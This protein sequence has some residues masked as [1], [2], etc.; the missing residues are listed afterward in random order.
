MNCADIELLIC[1]YVDGALGADDKAA[2]EAHLAQCPECAELAEESAAAVKF[3]GRA[4]AVE[5]PPQL[6]TRILFD[7]PWRQ[8][9]STSGARRWLDRFLGPVL[10]PRIVMGMAMTVLSFS[11]LFTSMKPFKPTDFEP[12]KVW[13]QFE[14]R[15]SRAWAR[16]VKYYDNLK[17]VYQIQTMLHEWQQ[18][19]EE[20]QRQK[21]APAALP[22]EHR[23]PAS[24]DTEKT[25]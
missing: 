20:A 5:P 17:V 2:V 6:I 21:A 10:Q 19:D 1:E 13:A 16:T 14:D 25:R 24:K 22:D 11:V 23:L 12:T 18:E 8:N 15:A 7:A 4:A 9:G 3:M